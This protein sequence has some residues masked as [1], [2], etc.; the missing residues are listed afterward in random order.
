MPDDD[1]YQLARDDRLRKPGM[2]EAQVR[3][4]LRDPRA[5]ALTENFAGQWL[6]LRNLKGFMPDPKLFP[7]FDEAL[8]SAMLKET[9][10]FFEHVV[11]EDRSVLEFLDANYT[12]VNERLAKHYGLPD[13]K[14]EQFRKVTLPP[15]PRGGVLTHASVLTITSN[16]T[17]T[18]PVKRGKWILENIL[19]TPPPP[20]PPGVE[21][22]KEDKQ[23]VL[24][25]T[26]RQRMEQHRANPSCAVCHAKLDPLGFGFENFDAVGAWR[27]R[28]A[29]HLIDPSGVLPGG[30]TFQ[31]PAELRAILKTR[32]E[33][34]TRCLADK[35]LT[36]A[37]GRGT[38]RS[39]RCYV[40]DIAR[41]VAKNEYRFSSLVL[42]IVKSEPFQMRRGKRGTSK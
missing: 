14:G 28:E 4:M 9:E 16:P 19:G 37:L 15:G 40:E 10:Q 12:F 26:L 6:Q 17:R 11:R 22:L 13:V 33:A 42:E 29:G 24:S 34:F 27:T 36:Y 3:R 41:T 2:L 39:D 8:R 5:R 21:E 1:L 23:T 31:G 7:T 20:P 18:S 25:G 32:H 38:E 30:Q 35:L